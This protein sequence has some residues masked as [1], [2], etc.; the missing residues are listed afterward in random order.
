MT[1][2][3]EVGQEFR[4]LE[5]CAVRARAW[6]F[7]EAAPL[8]CDPVRR[9]HGLFAEALGGNGIPLRVAHRVRV[10]ARQIYSFC[11]LGKLGWSGDWRTPVGETLDVLLTRGRRKDGFFIH[12]FDVHGQPEDT[13]S[14]TIEPQSSPSSNRMRRRQPPFQESFCS[15]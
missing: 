2:T 5:D 1:E 10:Q 9:A 8:W 14:V 6:L 11:A 12:T 3:F 15:A 7:S 4:A 13:R